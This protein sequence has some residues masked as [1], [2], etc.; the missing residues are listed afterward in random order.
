MSL[1]TLDTA[2]TAG[3]MVAGAILVLALTRRAFGGV[4]V[5]LGD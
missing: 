5:G 2:K 3:L 4:R 1:P